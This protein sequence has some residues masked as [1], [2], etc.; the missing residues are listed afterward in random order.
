MNNEIKRHKFHIPILDN[1]KDY[2]RWHNNHKIYHGSKSVQN[3]LLKGQTDTD[4]FNF[5]CPNCA[6]GKALRIIDCAY[7]T[8]EELQRYFAEGN[9]VLKEHKAMQRKS[10]VH[11]RFILYCD[12]CR[13][14]DMVKVAN[15]GI[16]TNRHI[17]KNEWGIGD[18]THYIYYQPH[19]EEQSLPTPDYIQPPVYEGGEPQ[20]YPNSLK[21]I[22]PAIESHNIGGVYFIQGEITGRI[23]IGHSQD[24]KSRLQSL[25]SSEPLR[26]T[27]VIPNESRETELRLHK[28]FSHLRVI[29]EWFEGTQELVYYINSLRSDKIAL[30]N[31]QGSK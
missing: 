3:G 15:L 29:G 13:F 4:Y 1:S 6:D 26:L 21:S 31:E 10:L 2:C 20:S 8:G 14:K 5:L 27:H 7:Q 16:Q 22:M 19:T 12:E 23:K 25:Q 18:N 30:Q 17:F 9:E 28:K 11:L 24:I